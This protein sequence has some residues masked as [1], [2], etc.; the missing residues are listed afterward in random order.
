V[1][2]ETLDV[3][4]HS[5]DLKPMAATGMNTDPP[6]LVLDANAGSGIG[7]PLA[8]I[9]KPFSHRRNGFRDGYQP[10]ELFCFDQERHSCLPLLI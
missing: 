1:E 6:V 5:G 3:D 10:F 7:R 9:T 4:E 8:L 2:C